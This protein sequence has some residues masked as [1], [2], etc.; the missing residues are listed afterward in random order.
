MTQ[1]SSSTKTTRERAN[2]IKSDRKILLR[3]L[4][5]ETSSDH[6][7]NN[8]NFSQQFYSTLNDDQNRSRVENNV[9]AVRNNRNEIGSAYTNW[10]VC[11]E[12]PFRDQWSSNEAVIKA[13]DYVGN[14]LSAKVFPTEEMN[15]YS[16]RSS[17]SKEDNMTCHETLPF[18]AS[19]FKSIT[20]CG[21]EQFFT[22]NL[23]ELKEKAEVNWNEFANVYQDDI[24]S[25][26][27]ITRNPT[28]IQL[29]TTLTPLAPPCI[30][31]LKQSHTQLK[32]D[33]ALKKRK[34][35]EIKIVYPYF[36]QERPHAPK[37]CALR[38]LEY[39]EG[40]DF[41]S[42]SVLNHLWSKTAMDNALWE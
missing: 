40:S 20:P 8:S 24:Q 36:G 25:T 26:I 15:R 12:K 11:V 22:H 10:D 29:T 21:P 30:N 35:D 16:T 7:I 4:N 37:V 5:L 3:G 19:G 14:E 18:R 6:L 9:S 42:V 2:S 33:Q 34:I 39:L 13:N 31:K 1:T 38:C 28:T 23:C 17:R 32:T 27:C 41:Y